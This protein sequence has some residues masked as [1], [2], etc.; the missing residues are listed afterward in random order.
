MPNSFPK[1]P[2]AYESPENF[3]SNVGKFVTTAQ[4]IKTLLGLIVGTFFA[5][6]AVYNHFAK[7]EELAELA[8]K[9][10]E[11]NQIN[12]EM[13][14]ANSEIQTAFKILKESFSEPPEKPISSKF[15]AREIT[16]AVDKIGNS[17]NKVNQIR[18]HSQIKAI[19]KD[20]KC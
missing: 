2:A 17:L 16:A 13:I 11:Q 15:I 18:Q 6:L 20:G 10:V 8:C 12:N 19:K 7:S 5:G 4:L 3:I 1:D 14:I 9:V